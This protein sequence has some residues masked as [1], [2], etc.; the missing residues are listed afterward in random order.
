METTTMIERLV[1]A[2]GTEWQ[3]G[4]AHRVYFNDLDRWYGLRVEYYES[5]NIRSATLSGDAISNAQARAIISNL[6]W[7]KVWF[8]V[9]DGRFY[10]SGDMGDGRAAT[11]ITTMKAAAGL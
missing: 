6:R 9:T 7:S 3:K 4:N 2:G 10:H 11:I 8:N 5:G 1:E